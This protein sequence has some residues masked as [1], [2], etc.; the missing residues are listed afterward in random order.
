MTAHDM[1]R[2]RRAKRGKLARFLQVRQSLAERILHGWLPQI[3]GGMRPVGHPV[4]VSRGDPHVRLFGGRHAIKLLRHLPERR[5]RSRA[6]YAGRRHGK[7]FGPDINTLRRPAVAAE[8]KRLGCWECD[9][10]HLRQSF[11]EASV[12]SLVERADRLAVLLA[13][14][15]SIATD[16]GAARRR[17]AGPLPCRSCSIIIDCATAFNARPY[18]QGGYR[19]ETSLCD[20][21]SPRQ[22][23]SIENMKGCAGNWL[24]RDVAPVFITRSCGRLQ[25]AEC[26][27]TQMPWPRNAGQSLSNG[28]ARTDQAGWPA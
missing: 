10:I 21:Q 9:L 20:A 4:R 25:S 7:R 14:A 1:A 23:D 24:S 28:T 5:V 6:R 27:A 19:P 11:G 8:R 13:T 17:V 15:A 18:L 3:A 16:L 12:T 22:E 2:G 26:D